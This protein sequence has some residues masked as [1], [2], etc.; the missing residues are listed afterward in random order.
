MI[1]ASGTTANLSAE[2]NVKF[3]TPSKSILYLICIIIAHTVCI[4]PTYIQ[5]QFLKQCWTWWAT[6]NID[7]FQSTHNQTPTLYRSEVTPRNLYGQSLS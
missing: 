6:T 5:W 2:V 3:R 7:V 1:C 4:I